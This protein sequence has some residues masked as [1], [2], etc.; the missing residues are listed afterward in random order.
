MI[1][2]NQKET[3]ETEKDRTVLTRNEY[4]PMLVIVSSLPRKPPETPEVFRILRCGKKY[5]DAGQVYSNGLFGACFVH[6]K[7]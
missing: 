4:Q 7:K 6:M 5:I 1:Y 3:N 2:F